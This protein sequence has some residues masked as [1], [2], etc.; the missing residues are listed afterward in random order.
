M[1][2]AWKDSAYEKLYCSAEHLTG[3]R[4]ELISLSV[5]NIFLS[6]T[7]IIGNVLI[8]VALWVGQALSFCECSTKSNDVIRF[9]ILYDSNVLVTPGGYFLIRA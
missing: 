9:L 2:A 5:L 4:G 8:Q 7:A 3:M 6:L 1:T